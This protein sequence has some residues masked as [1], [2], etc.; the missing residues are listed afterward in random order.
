MKK[1]VL[2]LASFL[3]ITSMLFSQSN[4]VSYRKIESLS[5]EDL[6][7]MWKSNGIPKIITKSKNEV[8]IY[9]LIYITKFPD[10]TE[11]EASGVYYVPIGINQELATI[12][13]NHGTTMKNRKGDNYDYNGES[14]ICKIY[15]ADGYLV[16]WQDYIGL[17]K[18]KGFHPY[19]HLETQGQ[20]GADLLLACKQINKELNIKTNNQL[21]I[22]GYSQGG[23]ATLSV[24][25]VLQEKYADEFTVTASSPMSGAHDMS[26][27]QNEIMEIEYSQPHYL[28]YLLYGYQRMYQILPS[29]EEFYKVF[30]PEYRHVLDKIIAKEHGVADINAMLPKK[31]FEM[32][33]DSF[34]HV[35]KTDPTFNFTIA[36][37]Q[38]NTYNWVPKAPVQFCYCKGD[39][40]V[41][42]KNSTKA[43]KWMRENGATDIIDREVSDKL[44]TH[45]GCASYAAMFSKFF[46]DNK[47]KGKK[48][49]VNGFKA[50]LVKIAVNVDEGKKKKALKKAEKNKK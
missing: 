19:Q 49:D 33:S 50:M 8:D 31:P 17:G 21:F 48:N 37:K 26:G 4:L 32:I 39:E 6:N 30:K 34:F 42:Y 9:E 5:K 23:H 44:I 13:Y 47:R 20:S 25:K 24:H 46:F 41:Y 16:A 18:G 3:M 29:V 45:H 43:I 35:Y 22:T 36:L 12:Q 11:V 15:S 10:G 40:E 27:V 2:V 7:T 1:T 28:P 38:N 14:T